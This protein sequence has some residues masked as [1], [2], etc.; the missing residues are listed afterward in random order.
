[1]EGVKKKSKEFDHI[2]K[3]ALSASLSP[4]TLALKVATSRLLKLKQKLIN[5]DIF[6]KLPSSRFKSKVVAV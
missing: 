4:K 6:R 2:K 3:S 5:D 1:L